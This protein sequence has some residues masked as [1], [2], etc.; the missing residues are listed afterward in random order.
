M[1]KILTF[2]E[3]TLNHF[4]ML[5]RST[6]KKCLLIGVIGGWCNGLKYYVEPTNSD[7]EKFG[8]KLL[9]MI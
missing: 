4:N 5:L 1:K 7:T 9:L 6:N 3:L 2:C 8:E